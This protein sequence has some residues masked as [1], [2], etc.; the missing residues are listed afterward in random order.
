MID[1]GGGPKAEEGPSL[2]GPS[3]GSGSHS[4]GGPGVRGTHTGG[5]QLA[6][7]CRGEVPRMHTLT[8]YTAHSCTCCHLGQ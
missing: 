7:G 4:P 3:G 6:M 5:P 8:F 2:P 1:R